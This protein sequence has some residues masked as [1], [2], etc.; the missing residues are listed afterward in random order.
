MDDTV[1]SRPIAATPAAE[2]K[3][4]LNR[5]SKALQGKKALQTEEILQETEEPAARRA[6]GPKISKKLGKQQIAWSKDSA[7]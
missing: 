7:K 2:R 5:L 6:E 4:S 1:T 3:F